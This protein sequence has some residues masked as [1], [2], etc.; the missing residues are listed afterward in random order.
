MGSLLKKNIMPRWLTFILVL[1][2]TSCSLE[3]PR[4]IAVKSIRLHELTDNGAKVK[5]AL[6]VNN[7]NKHTIKI[8]GGQL[9][10]YVNNSNVGKIDVPDTIELPK[11]SEKE[12]FL[13]LQTNY[14]QVFN[15]LGS[16]LTMFAKRSAE[17]TIKG[18]IKAG[19]YFIRKTFPVNV[20]ENI[21][22]DSLKFN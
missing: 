14:Q 5:I 13:H 7:P 8:R 17:V 6:V 4:I 12:Y 3:P 20:T 1:V 22:S 21:S 2:L 9:Q 15:S 16:L 11:K 10:V 18:E 19:A